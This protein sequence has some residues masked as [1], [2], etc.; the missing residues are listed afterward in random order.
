MFRCFVVKNLSA[1]FEEEL[2]IGLL[3]LKKRLGIDRPA[4]R[5][6]RRLVGCLLR[7][8]RDWSV[9]FEKWTGIDGLFLRK[10]VI[11]GLFLRKDRGLV[12]CF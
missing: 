9:A 8:G 1:V 6:G 10:L 4:L 2:G 7:K 12:G 11:G 3:F 5:N